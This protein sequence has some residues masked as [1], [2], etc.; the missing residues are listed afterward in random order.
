MPKSMI[1]SK[2]KYRDYSH[3]MDI[4]I[5]SSDN[6]EMCMNSLLDKY[7]MMNSVNNA[8][9][10]N[11]K[12]Q[13]GNNNPNNN[14]NNNNNNRSNNNNIRNKITTRTIRTLG[15]KDPIHS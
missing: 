9:H 15:D 12:V 13:R 5:A 6:F 4:L 10:Q 8:H 1:L 11:N 3:I 7:N 14:R 2:V